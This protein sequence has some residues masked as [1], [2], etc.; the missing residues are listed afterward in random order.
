MASP[1]EYKDQDPVFELTGLDFNDKK[2]I[3]KEFKNKQGLIKFYAPWCPHCKTMVNDLNFLANGL[4]ENKFMIGAVN[5]T[6]EA[7]KEIAQ[8]MGVS[9]IPSL[10]MLNTNGEL[11]EAK[12]ANRSIE[13]MLD[14]ICTYTNNTCYEKK[15][16]QLVKK[17]TVVPI[18][19][20]GGDYYD[21][22][23]IESN[24]SI[25]TNSN[26]FSVNSSIENFSDYSSGSSD[27]S[28]E[29]CR[30]KY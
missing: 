19:S 12:L 11:E 2:L 7:N 26:D 22:S 13:G 25:S 17:T 8:K 10:F 21:N 27:Y 5:V 14:K 23:H 30:R 28:C 3:K 1:N 16:N 4:K 15:D 29:N 6:Q 9:G 20:G 18:Q 24:S